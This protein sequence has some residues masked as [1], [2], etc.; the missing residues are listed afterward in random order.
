MIGV[1]DLREYGYQFGY[2][3]LATEGLAS[4]ASAFSHFPSHIPL[5]VEVRHENWFNQPENTD[6]WL[7]SLARYKRTAVITDVAGR[8]DVLHMG[9]T[10]SL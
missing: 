3:S 1:T 10:G 7:K 5:A 8:R 6:K 9:L 2:R 4:C